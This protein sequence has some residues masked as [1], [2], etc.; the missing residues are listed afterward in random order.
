MKKALNACLTCGACC[1]FFRASFYYQETDE[2]SPGG[3]P[4]QLTEPLN[5]FRQVMKG[6]KH[7]PV[8]CVALEGEI[9]RTVCCSIHPR[10]ST[11]CREFPASYEDGVTPNERCDRARAAQGLLPLKPEDWWTVID[12][13]RPPEQ[14][15]PRSAE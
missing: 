13:D 9:G 14:V 7:A 2:F 8:R 6:T 3:V 4:A 11:V 15:P 10:R 1:A 5:Q 12:D